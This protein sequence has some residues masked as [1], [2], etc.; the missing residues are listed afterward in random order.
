[1][2]K[3]SLALVVEDFEIVPERHISECTLIHFIEL[4]I[5]LTCVHRNSFGGNY[6]FVPPTVFMVKTQ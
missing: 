3:F 1:M 6:R 4:K 5:R 2:K